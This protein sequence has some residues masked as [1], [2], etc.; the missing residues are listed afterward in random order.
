MQL[1]SGEVLRARAVVVATD[2]PAAAELLGDAPPPAGNRTVCLY[3]A[4]P[5]P[6]VAEPIL[7]LNG[8]GTGPINNLCVPSQVAPGYAPAGRALVSVSIVGDPGGGSE[9][10]ERMVRAQLAGWF[11]DAVREWEHLRSDSIAFALPAQP[12]AALEPPHRPVRHA[13]GVFICGDHLDSASIQGAMV[14]GRRAADAV[15]DALAV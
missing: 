9:S 15:R 2:Q 11:G 5:E 14:S 4:A 8:D 1:D 13:N 6:P 10:L 12:P 3:Y 7:V